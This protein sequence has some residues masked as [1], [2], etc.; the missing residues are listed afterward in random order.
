MIR[1][2][3]ILQRILMRFLRMSWQSC[4]GIKRCGQE[5]DTRGPDERAES[6][7]VS[8][9]K[10][11][12]IL[13]AKKSHQRSLLSHCRKWSHRRSVHYL[14]FDASRECELLSRLEIF[15]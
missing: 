10:I 15:S 8:F 6:G 3:R 14:R 2:T 13:A 7:A 11:A 4:I 5:Y 9:M 12:V 1:R